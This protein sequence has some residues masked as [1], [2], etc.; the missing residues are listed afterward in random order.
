MA[1]RR[2]YG[3][4]FASPLGMANNEKKN[5]GQGTSSGN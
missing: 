4:L 3:I 5:G 2:T 1:L